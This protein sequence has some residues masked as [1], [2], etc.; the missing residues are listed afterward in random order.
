MLTNYE[1]VLSSLKT[2]VEN[3]ERK[4][5]ESSA[6]MIKYFV[7]SIEH[8]KEVYASIPAGQVPVQEAID[9][10]N[11]LGLVVGIH[12][13]S[14]NYIGEKDWNSVTLG[15]KEKLQEI[16]E[17]LAQNPGMTRSEI[18]KHIGVSSMTATNR[19]KDLIKFNK[20]RQKEAISQGRP[21]FVYN[22]VKG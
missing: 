2:A 7:E 5:K 19:L 11:E 9:A 17:T 3:D 8:C 1:E 16:I 10:V 18:A 14:N 6:A 22:L 21:S 13:K 20:V 4:L 12:G 15:K